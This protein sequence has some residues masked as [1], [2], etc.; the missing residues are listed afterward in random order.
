MFGLF[1]S[2]V[3]AAVIVTCLYALSPVFFHRDD[4]ANEYLPYLRK[5]AEI[6]KS[7]EFPYLTPDSFA[8][9]NF[10]IDF[11]RS[12]LN[13]LLLIACLLWLLTQSAV[14]VSLIFAGLVVAC[15]YF[16]GY[17][18]GI[19]ANV[20][21]T[22]SHLLG[23]TISTLPLV[24]FSYVGDWWN[25]A[26]GTVA[27]TFFVASVVAYLRNSGVLS[28][29]AVFLATGFVFASGW[30]H[31][32]VATAVVLASTTLVSIMPFVPLSKEH[33]RRTKVR[34]IASL[35]VVYLL[36][37]MATWP[38]FSEYIHLS[39]ISARPSSWGNPG[40][41][42]VPSLLQLAA[43]VNPI[44]AEFW[45]IYGGYRFW[46][47]SIGFVS[48]I[49]LVLIFFTRTADWRVVVKDQLIAVVGISC[50]ILYLLTQLP[51]Q[52][53]PLRYSFRFLP[54]AEIALFVAVVRAL[55]ITHRVWSM[56]RWLCATGLWA[57]VLVVFAWRVEDPA[58]N[59][60][61]SFVAPALLFLS[62][63]AV[64]GA[65]G[66][67]RRSRKASKQDLWQFSY[68]TLTLIGIVMFLVQAPS[69][70]SLLWN[71]T[72]PPKGILQLIDKATAGGFVANGLNGK[73]KEQE[74][75]AGRLLY[76]DSKLFN[77]YDPNGQAKYVE[78]FQPVTVQG[79]IPGR[80]VKLLLSS[81]E[82]PFEGHCA[83]DVYRITGIIIT[84]NQVKELS[85]AL[86]NCGYT[87]TKKWDDT[88]LLSRVLSGSSTI[89]SLSLVHG[90]AARQ[91]SAT[92][93]SEVVSVESTQDESDSTGLVV[94]AREYW[95]GYNAELDNG[96]RL[97]VV[98]VEHGTAVGVE[99][100]AHVGGRL[101][102]TYSPETWPAAWGVTVASW[103]VL[104]VI[105]LM[106]T[107]KRFTRRRYFEGQLRD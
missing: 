52:L 82:E 20:R 95:P 58:A 81:A 86:K 57:V 15:L 39:S 35:W 99:I 29:L 22:Y 106:P 64:L 72:L 102:L 65:V 2:I 12:V 88:V 30:P 17:L 74:I 105:L 77:G 68:V 8:G 56:K 40:N 34:H 7:G 100:P 89:G 78:R 96:Q 49:I 45:N 44:G 16:G 38:V 107:L 10:S 55:A 14:A 60:L 61:R 23:A 90:V 1:A 13:P 19:F 27:F 5:A 101:T 66:G 84:F 97:K 18:I 42:G 32:Y 85:P 6:L 83:A 31:G 28:L 37:A 69:Y 94:F 53:G 104:L 92:A 80:S 91:I 63:S 71:G 9:G 21:F 98:P 59:L 4:A 33:E 26:T 51:T 67:W 11:Q 103:G 43:A 73:G 75:G 41:F 46:P 50:A 79:A 70:N 87:V 76:S 25:A 62:V 36:G 93:G 24:L 48:L 47:V 3:F 54:F